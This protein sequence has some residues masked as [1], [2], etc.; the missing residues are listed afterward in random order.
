MRTHLIPHF[1]Y[2][3]ISTKALQHTRHQAL[4]VCGSFAA[5]Y[6]LSS[7]LV[8]S[9]AASDPSAEPSPRPSFGDAFTGC[10]DEIAKFEHV[11][12]AAGEYLAMLREMPTHSLNQTDPYS[13]Q[14]H[15]I[16]IER[17]VAIANL[18]YTI[19]MLE[20]QIK[21][22]DRDCQNLNRNKESKEN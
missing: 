2:P 10:E 21:E 22:F 12:A 13:G 20:N 1:W 9:T 8:I 14:N 16:I 3:Q 15:D 19:S 5:A 6:F 17:M 11:V 18:K 7:L 4:H